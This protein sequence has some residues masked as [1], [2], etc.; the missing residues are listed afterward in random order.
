M[1][2]II[3][4]GTRP[5]LQAQVR[6]LAYVEGEVID[7][8]SKPIAELTTY[9]LPPVVKRREVQRELVGQV[10][11]M[12]EAL[13][14]RVL[15]HDSNSTEELTKLHAEARRQAG[16][17][18]PSPSRLTDEE[19]VALAAPSTTEG[20]PGPPLRGSGDPRAI[21]AGPRRGCR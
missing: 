6:A 21:R 7:E 10:A 5:F 8:C 13:A 1:E 18:E 2:C 12:G 15:P 16:K 11:A 3:T 14:F 19:R 9:F 20:N 4:E 17:V